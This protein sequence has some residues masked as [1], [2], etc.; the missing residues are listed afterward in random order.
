MVE[1][2]SKTTGG[3]NRVP[4]IEFENKIFKNQSN[5]K[6]QARYGKENEYDDYEDNRSYNSTNNGPCI[7]DFSKNFR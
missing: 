6:C 1:G 7:E 4:P 5:M 3:Q 2:Y